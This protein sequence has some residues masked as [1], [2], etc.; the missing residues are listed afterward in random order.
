MTCMAFLYLCS[1]HNN[2]LLHC[3]PLSFNIWHVCVLLRIPVCNK[4][5]EHALWTHPETHFPL[6]RSLNNKQNIAPLTRIGLS[7]S[8]QF[9]KIATRQ[10]CAWTHLFFIPAC[11]R[12]HNWA[13]I[14]LVFKQHGAERENENCV[15]LKIAKT[16]APH[17]AGCMIDPPVW[18]V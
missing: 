17:C 16:R 18:P 12:A 4:K 2:I 9:L 3:N 11:P 14:Y 10:Q 8:F 5:I 1:Q 7:W 15:G 6:T 13:Q